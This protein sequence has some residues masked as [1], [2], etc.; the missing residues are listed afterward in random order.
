MNYLL[1]YL[2]L[3]FVS[4]SFLQAAAV[5]TQQRD[6]VYFYDTWEQM[7][8][9]T[10]SSMI[11]SPVI[12]VLSPYEIDIYTSTDDYRLYD[13]MAA[14]IGDSIMLISSLYLR[15]TFKGDKRDFN[16]NKFYPVFFNEKVAYVVN[17]TY[18]EELSLKELLFG[19]LEDTE[20]IPVY[21]YLDFMKRRVRKVTPAVLSELLEDYHDLQMRYEGM[22][23]YK[24]HEII[25][26]Y[27]FK[28]IDR[29][30]QDFMRPYILDI[31][32]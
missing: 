18:G 6:T 7:L 22:K 4:L 17:L 26:D 8:D 21:Y 10:P 30:T 25:E 13:H 19:N 32:D 12:E 1:K 29:A 23:N 14:S 5:G 28:Y 2:S 31:A 24:K 9:M 20:G 11:V 16:S 27:F 3:A 15:T